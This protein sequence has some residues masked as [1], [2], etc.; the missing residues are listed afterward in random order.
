MGSNGKDDVARQYQ[1]GTPINLPETLAAA[2]IE[3]LEVDDTRVIVIYHQ[4]IIMLTATDGSPSDAT[5]IKA[6]LWEPPLNSSTD[7]ADL[8]S[9]LI[10]ELLTLT[11]AS[12]VK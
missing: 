5:V 6:E 9:A 10:D 4:A 11:D 1:F 8:L 12:R 3:A 7:P 2:G